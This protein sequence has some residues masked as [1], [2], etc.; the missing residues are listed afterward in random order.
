LAVVS[1]LGGQRIV[2][3][4]SA[5]GKQKW[6]YHVGSRVDYPPALHRGLC[7]FSAA[8]GWVYCVDAKTGTLV[9]KNMFAER[10]RYIGGRDKI[11]RA[12]CVDERDRLKMNLPGIVA[13]NVMIANGVG[14][15]GTLAFKPETGELEPAPGKL[16]IDR[17]L[18]SSCPQYGVYLEDTLS[19]GN[20]LP[21]G[22]AD[23]AA[24]LFSDGRVTGRTVSFDDAL[25][26]AYTGAGGD[27]WEC[28][29]QQLSLTAVGK[30]PKKPIWKTP[31]GELVVDDI[32]L[33]PSRIYAIGHYQRIKKD[34]DI[35]VLSREDGKVL[36]TVPVDG[37]PAFMG[38]SAAGNRLFV[39]T[40]EGRLICYQGN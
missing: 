20:S 31:P 30:D 32:V 37:Y 14:Y 4:D 10:E 6:A 34:P 26:V 27:R 16:A 7:L 9:W 22:T 33:T 13:L 15:I 40:R 18:D 24:F 23:R 19:I 35:W 1:D 28:A 12:R 25:S 38:M 17:R 36:N 8:D 2:A 39:S 29:K 11:E 21:R 5:S 3:V